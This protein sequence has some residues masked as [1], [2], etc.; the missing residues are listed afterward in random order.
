MFFKS[1]TKHLY[2]DLTK[3][4][5]MKPQSMET[6]KKSNLSITDL[7]KVVNE[8]Y[9]ENRDKNKQII[10]KY[11]DLRKGVIKVLNLNKRDFEYLFTKLKEEK[12]QLINLHGTLVGDYQKYVN[13]KYRGRLYPFI[14]LTK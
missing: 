1:Y 9:W 5:Y 6:N 10:M 3:Y 13:F 12:W 4:S 14:S 2:N 11:S 7:W 8:V